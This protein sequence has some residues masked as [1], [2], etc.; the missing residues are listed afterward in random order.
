MRRCR[1]KLIHNFLAN[2]M[3]TPHDAFGVVNSRIRIA[4]NYLQMFSLTVGTAIMQVDDATTHG[5][6][7]ARITMRNEVAVVQNCAVR[8]HPLQHIRHTKASV[9]H[10][11]HK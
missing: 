9:G 3:R 7:R 10:W 1:S 8:I 2:S 6:L 5:T 4:I 11:K